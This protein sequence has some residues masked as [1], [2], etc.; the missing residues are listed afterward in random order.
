MMNY[1]DPPN[2][3]FDSSYQPNFHTHDRS[4]DD[5]LNEYDTFNKYSSSR[6]FNS[7][8]SLMDVSPDASFSALDP[9]SI[10]SQRH[11]PLPTRV[12]LGASPNDSLQ[13][14]QEISLVSS[15]HKSLTNQLG[16]ILEKLDSFSSPNSPSPSK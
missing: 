15:T 6:H 8:P 12:D 11:A 9:N 13:L 4:W 14:R 2:N 3:N 5:N 1:E 16:S 7:N 10:L